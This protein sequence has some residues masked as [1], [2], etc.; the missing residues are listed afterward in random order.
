MRVGT[1]ASILSVVV[2]GVP[3]QIAFGDE[4]I[5]ASERKGRRSSKASSTQVS[6]VRDV[7]EQAWED[8]AFEAVEQV[9]DSYPLDWLWDLEPQVYDQ[10]QALI[11]T[12]DDAEAFGA[13]DAQLLTASPQRLY[14][15]DE[16]LSVSQTDEGELVAVLNTGDDIRLFILA[17]DDEGQ[18]SVAL[19]VLIAETSETAEEE[20]IPWPNARKPAGAGTVASDPCPEDFCRGRFPPCRE[21]PCE[22]PPECR[23]RCEFTLPTCQM[24]E[25]CDPCCMTC[26]CFTT[27]TDS[28]E[29]VNT[30]R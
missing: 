16:F 15:M 25:Q 9:T 7:Q 26:T 10:L 6:E 19:D 21:P 18:A 11:A 8:Q 28:F 22:H 17:V 12:I 23:I 1:I 13:G 20:T 24:G 3:A 5:G 27:A 2:M 14:G 29:C 30:C 4:G